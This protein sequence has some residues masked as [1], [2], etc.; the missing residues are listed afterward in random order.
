MA[1]S[2]F[3]LRILS[4]PADGNVDAWSEWYAS[5]GLPTLI[6]KIP[7]S[8]AFFYHAYNDFE[9]KTK[10][11]LEGRQTRLHSVELA[12]SDLEPPNDKTCLAMCQLDSMDS[13][14]GIFSLS[15]L[16]R[17]LTHATVSDIRVYK[18]IEDFDPKG[19]GHRE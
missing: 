10:T 11:P 16:T 5:E 8:R 9:L 15:D 1:S 7:V 4:K 17:D 14:Q 18:L 6:S 3:L 13:V 12:H 19:I 2:P